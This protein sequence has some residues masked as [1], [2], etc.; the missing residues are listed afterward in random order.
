M[1][2]LN[3]ILDETTIINFS[4]FK[5]LLGRYKY[6]SIIIVISI[7][8]IF[9]I[10]YK[11]QH[12]IYRITKTFKNVSNDAD[13]PLGTISN[14]IGESKKGITEEEVISSLSSIDFVKKFAEVVY[15]SDQYLE[16]NLSDLL[17][18]DV[19]STSEIYALCNED[20]DC[21]INFLIGRLPALYEI[22]PNGVVV[23]NFFITV[24]TLDA[25]TSK[26]LLKY[27]EESIQ[28]TRLEAIKRVHSQQNEVT[29]KLLKQK[30]EE[31]GNIDPDA[32]QGEFDNIKEK[33]EQ[34]DDRISIVS[35]EYHG[36]KVQVDLL[37]SQLEQTK[38]T[39]SSDAKKLFNSK[40]AKKAKVIQ[41]KIEKYRQDISAIEVASNEFGD[42]SSIL[43]QL[44]SELKKAER[45]LASIPNH[46]LYL[47]NAEDFLKKKG[48][49]SANVN[50]DNK[51]RKRQ[52]IRVNK[53][54]E[55]L[56]FERVN[57]VKRQKE[58]AAT[59]KQIK[60]TV[61]YINLLREKLVQLQIIES[62]I[63]SDY[64]FSKNVS[65]ISVFKRT[66][67]SK[68]ILFCFF[69]TLFSLFAFVLIRYL[70][71]TKIYDEYELNKNYE[72]ID[73][74]GKTPDFNS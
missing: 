62:T 68:V 69:V 18:R 52:F 19:R 33:V 57:T 27:L 5:K 63:I 6:A 23:N 71:D 37:D 55:K 49:A 1:K 30:L 28:L 2:K 51:V 25:K 3:V 8:S 44:R 36:L 22:R 40:L 66:S 38:K 41:S 72:N 42:E 21:F 31:L 47:S 64:V 48:N 50:F 4:F 17:A 73:V 46:K 16:M 54:L 53:E 24:K 13:S 9:S 61:D 15:E 39:L 26:L 70:A 20:K 56:Q 67:L 29:Q 74:I 59:L 7:I 60:P 10:Y 35:R 14:I 12:D 43:N 34:L 65:G 45:E 32:I 58:L 11:N